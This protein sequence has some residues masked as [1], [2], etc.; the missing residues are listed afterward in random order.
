MCSCISTKKVDK[1][2]SH[3]LRNYTLGEEQPSEALVFEYNGQVLTD[4]VRITKLKRSFIPAIL[5]WGIRNTMQVD[6]NPSIYADYF[7]VSL[8]KYSEELGLQQ[9]LDGRKLHITLSDVPSS[10]VYDFSSQSFILLFFY[11]TNTGEVINPIMGDQPIYLNYKVSNDDQDIVLESSMVVGDFQKPL[12]NLWKSS[13]G[14]QRRYIEEV[15]TD[16]DSKA[17]KA[18]LSFI[19]EIDT[20]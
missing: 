19:D 7:K 1:A 14:F 18:V 9:K 3:A 17:K 10:F 6:I 13:K 11:V 16:I 12:R 4:S 15:K 8:Y 5:Y 20:L 2:I